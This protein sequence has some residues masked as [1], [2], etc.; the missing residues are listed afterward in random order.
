[1][2]VLLQSVCFKSPFVLLY[3]DLY[4]SFFLVLI[5]IYYT[6]IRLV[7][8][9]LLPRVN[10]KHLKYTQSDDRVYDSS[11]QQGVHISLRPDLLALC[12][13]RRVGS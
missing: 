13:R 6:C 7:L 2:D 5:K 11:K 10:D 1:M 3:G 9:S 4:S 8:L 12:T